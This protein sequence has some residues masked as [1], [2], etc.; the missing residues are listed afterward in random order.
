MDIN[1]E[2]KE[3][4]AVNG[5]NQNFDRTNFIK[6]KRIYPKLN[7]GIKTSHIRYFS[8]E[9]LETKLINGE[10]IKR[11]Y[12]VYSESLGSIFCAPCRLF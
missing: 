2:T 9:L 6:S 12:L 10:K 4:F 11:S 1:E 3:Y 8:T 5:F 7:K